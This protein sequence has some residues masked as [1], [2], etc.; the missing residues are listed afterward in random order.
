MVS[1]KWRETEGYIYLHNYFFLAFLHN[2]RITS[3]VLNFCKGVMM[4]Q[5]SISDAYQQSRDAFAGL[6]R[7]VRTLGL[8]AAVGVLSACAGQRVDNNLPSGGVVVGS[9]AVYVEQ[10]YRGVLYYAKEVGRT[11]E[12]HVRVQKTNEPFRPNSRSCAEATGG[13]VNLL[14]AAAGAGAGYVLAR[15]GIAAL[16]GAIAVYT[17]QRLV[18]EAFRGDQGVLQLQCLERAEYEKRRYGGSSV[19]PGY[20]SSGAIGGGATHYGGSPVY[21]WTNNQVAQGVASMR[22]FIQSHFG[23]SAQVGVKACQLT[24]GQNGM[25]L[26][27]SRTWGGQY[28]YIESPTFR[29]PA[30]LN[31]MRL[32]G[33]CF[34][35]T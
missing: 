9:R 29:N 7:H 8:V 3:I 28:F 13:Q 11:P 12:G 21:G 34:N 32:Q 16:G 25:S 4:A 6:A 30:R 18:D 10:D 5:F 22:G 26:V 35:V 2:R 24:G 23:G 27:T 1:Q 20:N 19:G 33:R 17:A 14:D 15:N 31:V